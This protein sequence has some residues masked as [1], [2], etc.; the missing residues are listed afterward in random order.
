MRRFLIGL[1][2]LLA[3]AGVSWAQDCPCMEDVPISCQLDPLDPCLSDYLFSTYGTPLEGEIE[4]SFASRIMDGQRVPILFRTINDKTREIV[5][6][7]VYIVDKREETEGGTGV[8]ELG[9]GTCGDA[10]DGI[11]CP[12][13]CGTLPVECPDGTLDL[14]MTTCVMTQL[15]PDLNENC[16]CSPENCG[17]E[18]AGSPSGCQSCF[19]CVCM[20]M[21]TGTICDGSGFPPYS[22]GGEGCGTEGPC[23]ELMPCPW[24]DEG[25]NGQ[26]TCAEDW[27]DC[28]LCTI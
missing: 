7:K 17:Q 21:G 12:G 1:I 10:C 11:G 15:F 23:S 27:D 6:W 18:C 5:A 9:L 26:P 25:P 14:I 3:F 16:W 22:S 20:C 19:W 28:D 8:I 2:L 24:G 4:G 13:N